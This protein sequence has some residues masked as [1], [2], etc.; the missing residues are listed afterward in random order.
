MSSTKTAAGPEKVDSKNPPFNPEIMKM[1]IRDMQ[2]PNHIRDLTP[3][4]RN[5]YGGTVINAVRY[6]P[7]FADAFSIL[8]PMTDASADTSYVDQYARV[9]LSYW[10]FY[11]ISANQR[12]TWLTHEAFHVLNNHFSRGAM[13]H[14]SPDMLNKTGDLEINTTLQGVDTMDLSHLLLPENYNLPKHLTMERYFGLIDAEKNKMIDEGRPG[15]KTGQSPDQSDSGDQKDSEDSGEKNGENTGQSGSGTDSEGQE[16]SNSSNG[17]GTGG[18]KNAEGSGGSGSETDS[19]GQSGSGQGSSNSGSSD[20]SDDEGNGGAQGSD[21]DEDG[22]ES[23]FDDPTM[24]EQ[25]QRLKKD[26]E[27][28]EASV[29]AGGSRFC[30]E[31][32][33]DRSQMADESDIERRSDASQNISRGNTRARIVSEVNSGHRGS[34][35]SNEFLNTVLSLMS[36]PKADW[37][38]IFRHAVGRSVSEV[39]PGLTIS[40]YRRVNRRY[41]QGSVIFPGRLDRNVRKMLAIDTS[42]SMSHADYRAVMS[43]VEGILKASGHGKDDFKAFCIDSEVKKMKPVSSVQSID[44]RG[45]GGTDM[46]VGF[47]FVNNLSRKNRPDIFILATDGYTNWNSVIEE[48]T[49]ATYPSILLITDRGGYGTVPEAL[50]KMTTVIDISDD[51]NRR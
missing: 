22:A 7:A 16:P 5:I 33:M 19:D 35:S 40:S 30:D 31:Q 48:V 28:G 32:T 13:H 12:V 42:G 49:K 23:E 39:Q 15:P 9:G 45:G 1:W 50:K 8:S 4:E 38:D 46:S 2:R 34:G 44:L 20:K 24:N 6:L 17:S 18:E 25:F 26:L 43:E 10:F 37:R 29:P 36:P 11:V 21:G 51:D 14:M 47:A 41:T 3:Y 27:A